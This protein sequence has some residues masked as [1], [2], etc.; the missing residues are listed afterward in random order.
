[1]ETPSIYTRKQ[2][3]PGYWPYTAVKEGRGFRT[4]DIEGPFY[5]HP[6]INGK[7]VWTKLAATTFKEAKEEA[8]KI[9][10]AVHAQGQGLTVA[11]A[12][13]LT[14]RV[15]I[16]NAVDTYLDQKSNKA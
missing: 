10:E 1:M 6:S 13:N 15:T 12:Q 11:E 3:R 8:V 16:R 14:G 2:K 9:F 7:Q 4:G 5:V